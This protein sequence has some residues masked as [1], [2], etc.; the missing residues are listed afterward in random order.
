MWT[1]QHMADGGRNL[2][3][4]DACKSSPLSIRLHT[5]CRLMYHT[6]L[7]EAQRAQLFTKLSI[8]LLFDI[9]QKIGLRW[10]DGDS[11]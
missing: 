8:D 7:F 4:S 10:R 3:A 5:H 2:E 1:C 9:E 11:V 6:A